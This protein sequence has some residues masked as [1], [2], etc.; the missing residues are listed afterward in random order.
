MTKF[1]KKYVLNTLIASTFLLSQ[2]VNTN[3][4]HYTVKEKAVDYVT[5][6]TENKVSTATHTASFY[7][8]AVSHGAENGAIAEG[9]TEKVAELLTI[10]VG[11]MIA[12]YAFSFLGSI[13]GFIKDI[14]AMFK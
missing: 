9:K 11:I 1:F 12:G 13:I 3:A 14:V 10:G 8:P 5:V 6:K 7:T 2:V 4:S